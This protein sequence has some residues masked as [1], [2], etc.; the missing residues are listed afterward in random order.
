MEGV[1]P[2]TLL[3]CVRFCWDRC[4][5]MKNGITESGRFESKLIVVGELLP[6]ECSAISGVRSAPESAVVIKFESDETGSIYLRI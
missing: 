6:V 3:L 5:E 1:V 4:R 2:R